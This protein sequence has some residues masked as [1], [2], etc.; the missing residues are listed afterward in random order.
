MYTKYHE[1]WENG[2]I[3]SKKNKKFIS[4]N[5]HNGNGYLNFGL[6]VEN[7]KMANAYVHIA[8]AKCFIP[9]PN[10]LKEVNHKDGNKQNNHVS[11]LEWVTRGENVKHSYDTKLRLPKFKD[12]VLA[13]KKANSHKV[14]DYYGNVFESQ[15]KAAK[16]Y[17]LCVSTISAMINGKIKNKYNLQKV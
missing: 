15:S 6:P 3:W 13:A 1:V 4:L 8:V 17:K 9:N 14:K 12:A 5:R 11:N 2:M 10:N 7:G 16:F